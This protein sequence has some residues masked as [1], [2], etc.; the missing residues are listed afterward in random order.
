MALIQWARENGLEDVAVVYSDTR[1][2][3]DHWEERVE[4]MEQWVR[5]IGYSPHRTESIGLEELV[6]KRKGWP[7]NGMQFCTLELKIRPAMEWLDKN[8]PEK[9]ATCLV[10]VRREE[11]IAR[12]NFPEKLDESPNHGGRP[13]W[14]PLATA[15][16]EQRD[17]L[18]LRAGVE[19]LPHRSMECFPCINSNRKDLR[20]L[21]E[22]E[23]RIAE[24]ERIESELGLSSKGKPRVMFRPA[25]FMG[26]TGIREVVRWAKS[27]R[28]KY[29]QDKEF[30]CEG[31]FCES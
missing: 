7:R 4:Q 19:P 8:D 6:K 30:D 26:A 17:A 21:S 10:G 5:S 23:K 1:W 27:D 28:G 14:A 12:K 24:V 29:N 13:L 11:S 15:T 2:A 3:A 22:D 16:T 9:R 25:K 20:T 31:G 18:L